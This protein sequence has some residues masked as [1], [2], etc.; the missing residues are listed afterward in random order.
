ML[1][2]IGKLVLHNGTL[3]STN[4]GKIQW[5]NPKRDRNTKNLTRILLLVLSMDAGFSFST[6]KKQIKTSCPFSGMRFASPLEICASPAS[7]LFV[8]ATRRKN[9]ILISNYCLR[10][11]PRRVPPLLWSFDPGVLVS[12]FVLVCFYSISH[13]SELSFFSYNHQSFTCG[14]E[15]LS[16]IYFL[17]PKKDNLLQTCLYFAL[18]FLYLATWGLLFVL[19]KDIFFSRVGMSK[20]K[21]TTKK[22]FFQTSQFKTCTQLTYNKVYIACKIPLNRF[23]HLL[24]SSR[25]L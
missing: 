5:A 10:L 8:R 6:Q 4:K 24:V 1:G 25:S 16:T 17:A 18:L 20:N 21:S 9:R 15:G 22:I 11:P 3:S 13:S 2:P 19:K 14:E 12:F 7:V 23:R